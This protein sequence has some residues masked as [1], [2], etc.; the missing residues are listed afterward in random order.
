MVSYDVYLLKQETLGGSTVWTERP[1]YL[2]GTPMTDRLI[3]QTRLSIKASDESTFDFTIAPTHPLYGEITYWNGFIVVKKNGKVYYKGR[4]ES[5]ETDLKGIKSVKTKGNLALLKDSFFSRYLFKYL[6]VPELSG[7]HTFLGKE[8]EP[9]QTLMKWAND[10]TP[11]GMVR[12]VLAMHY[13]TTGTAV[14]VSENDFTAV[15][16]PYGVQVKNT[17]GSGAQQEG[18]Y[19]TRDQSAM[20]NTFDWFKNELIQKTDGV[21]TCTF[22]TTKPYMMTLHI[23]GPR[24]SPAVASTGHLVQA[25]RVGKNILD[26]KI[27]T[28]TDALCTVFLPIGSSNS[29]IGKT[30]DFSFEKLIEAATGTTV[31]EETDTGYA[32][33]FS[34]DQL[35]TA[36][37]IVVATKKDT[38]SPTSQLIYGATFWVTKVDEDGVKHQ[39]KVHRKQ[40]LAGWTYGGEVLINP[41]DAEVALPDTNGYLNVDDGITFRFVPPFLEWKEGVEKYGRILKTK[42]W[43][44][45]SRSK[46]QAYAPAEFKKMIYEVESVTLTAADLKLVDN[47]YDS[48]EVGY[49]Y[50]I[51]SDGFDRWLPCLETSENILNPADIKFTF[52][53]KATPLTSRFRDIVRTMNYNPTS[54]N[55]RYTKTVNGEDITRYPVP[56][57][58]KGTGYTTSGALTAYIGET[59]A[60]TIT[61]DSGKR[62]YK[63]VVAMNG[64]EPISQEWTSGTYISFGFSIPDVSGPI[65][66][67]VNSHV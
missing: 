61:P 19:I 57:V 52:S 22:A 29:N 60:A 7:H 24:L 56:V 36:D 33:G 53:R 58:Y 37:T 26:R 27:Q 6:S 62:L 13:A 4:T 48:P 47:D 32:A 9:G 20:I 64:G 21:I 28:N 51:I 34:D 8:Y 23:F 14:L 55:Q 12:D 67:T 5:V 45:A 43:S 10:A 3:A 63:V 38:D 44:S 31:E 46:L 39:Y 50:H 15:E 49:E 1:I 2:H 11:L 30:I 65:V 17:S 25:F 35:L 54:S 16:N 40:T 42:T 59:Y 18:L 66:V 41:D